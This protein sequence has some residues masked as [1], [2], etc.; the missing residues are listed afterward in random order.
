MLK[1]ELYKGNTKPVTG[2][3]PEAAK[4]AVDNGMKNDLAAKP[5]IGKTSGVRKPAGHSSMKND[6]AARSV[7]GDKMEVK[8]PFND[9]AVKSRAE[10]AWDA[11]LPDG[12]KPV[13]DNFEIF[14]SKTKPVAGQKP[15]AFQDV[16]PVTK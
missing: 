5:V 10:D 6:V 15:A 13:P 1:N 14:A 11:K 4:P 8:K 2:K 12:I 9:G 7:T 3:T 16:K